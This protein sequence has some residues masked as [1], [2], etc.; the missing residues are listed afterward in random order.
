MR[1][2]IVLM[3]IFALTGCAGAYTSQ[4]HTQLNAAAKRELAAWAEVQKLDAAQCPQSTPDKP[5]AKTKAV[6]RNQCYE[7]L[8]VKHV[9]PVAI[10]S[11]QLNRLL[12]AN[13]KTAIAYKQ[14]KI[15]KDESNMQ[16]QENWTNY[17]ASLDAKGSAVLN[18]AAQRDAQLAQQQ[19]QY[20]QN[21]SR[22][23][24][25]AEAAQQRALQDDGI[26]NTNCRFVANQ[27]Q[28]Q[29]W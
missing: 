26:D 9:M 1:K 27:M 23:V 25:Q 24:M 21:L 6:E 14:G 4:T 19:Q 8:V 29:T 15:D 2:L 20:F 3:T 7:D 22:Q 16:V 17:T 12:V 5:L 28:C 11:T 13:K 10:D 18:A